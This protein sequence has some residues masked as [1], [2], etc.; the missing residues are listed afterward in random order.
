M[1]FVLLFDIKSMIKSTLTLPLF[2]PSFLGLLK[3]SL[4]YIYKLVYCYNQECTYIV[5]AILKVQF[6][7][8]LKAL[9]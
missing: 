9:Q 4:F 3:L 2:P 1:I 8:F 6:E 7:S 5:P